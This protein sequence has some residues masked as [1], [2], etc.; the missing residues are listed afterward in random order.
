MLEPSVFDFI[1][2]RKF[3]DFARDVFPTLLKS[4]KK[5]Y[6]FPLTDCFWVELGTLEKYKKIKK[7]MERKNF[8]I[9]TQ[10]P[11]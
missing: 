4:S 6:G 1:E 5:I 7:E 2:K 9:Q 11:L 8:M 10:K 3:S